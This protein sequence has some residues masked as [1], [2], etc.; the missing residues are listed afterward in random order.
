MTWTEISATYTELGNTVTVL[1]PAF[2]LEFYGDE[3]LIPHGRTLFEK[4]WDLFPD[5]TTFYC[6]NKRGNEYKELK[7]RSVSRLLKTLERLG[8]EA[9]FYMLKDAP[10]FHVEQYS[11]ELSMGGMFQRLYVGLPLSFLE[12]RGA[13]GAAAFFTEIVDEFPFLNATAGL[14]FHSVWARECEQEA[15]PVNIRAARRYWGLMV[16]NRGD[17]ERRYQPFKSAHWLTYI[18]PS[19]LEE[20]GGLDA[21][22]E[23]AGD[24]VGVVEA[25]G[26]VVVRAGDE[27]PIGDINRKAPDIEPMRRVN[28][29]I[30]PKRI[31]EWSKHY[32]NLFFTDIDE[33]NE[34]LTRLDP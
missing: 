2:A 17:E 22:K 25:G 7:P 15:M 18:G 34:W 6:I 32:S 21:A 28:A 5:E 27:P 11:A 31:S 24:E 26:G 9:Q 14:G 33:C 12:E 20:L 23:A 30:R 4:F 16:R 13:D 29:F 19:L 8:Q 1:R 10:D 3:A